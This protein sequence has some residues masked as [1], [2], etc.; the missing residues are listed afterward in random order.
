MHNKELMQ[1]ILE[2]KDANIEDGG[3]GTFY[4]YLKK[5]KKNDYMAGILSKVEIHFLRS[6]CRLVFT[7]VKVTLNLITL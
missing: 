7:L 5:I 1:L 3:S 6:F 4:I 2:I